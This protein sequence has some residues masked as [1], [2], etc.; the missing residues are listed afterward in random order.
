[1]KE[2]NKKRTENFL[3][4][5]KIGIGNVNGGDYVG[6]RKLIR[7]KVKIGKKIREQDNELK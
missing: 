3:E 5:K 1:M 7:N 6:I 4:D 2:T